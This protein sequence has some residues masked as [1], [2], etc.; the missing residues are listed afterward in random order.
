MLKKKK[1]THDQKLIKKITDTRSKFD[2]KKDYIFYKRF[3]LGFVHFII[4]FQIRPLY[5]FFIQFYDV[6]IVL[7]YTGKYTGKYCQ[8]FKVNMSH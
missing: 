8:L 6:C 4:W 1:L 2:K 3:V 5:G 7:L